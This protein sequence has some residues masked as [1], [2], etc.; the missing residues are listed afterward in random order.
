MEILRFGGCCLSFAV[1]PIA[2]VIGAAAV[3]SKVLLVI[4]LVLF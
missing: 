3:Y 2:V 1:D 4:L